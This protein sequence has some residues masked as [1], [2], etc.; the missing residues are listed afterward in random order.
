MDELELSGPRD[1]FFLFLNNM[2]WPPLSS[3]GGSHE[4]LFLA[5]V[6]VSC[7]ESSSAVVSLLGVSTAS[8][9]LGFVGSA[10]FGV[11]G[12]AGFV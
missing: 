4:I 10:I 3:V 7:M 5:I 9:T 11:G 12:L 6:P 8:S 2:A 1:S